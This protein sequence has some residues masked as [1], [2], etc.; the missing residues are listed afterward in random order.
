MGIRTKASRQ[1]KFVS[2]GDLTHHA[3]NP[4]AKQ[5]QKEYRIV[6]LLKKFPLNKHTNLKL[7]DMN[8]TNVSSGSSLVAQLIRT[9]E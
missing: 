7:I 6:L 5:T 3:L 8:K 4:S 9:K 1:D 2:L